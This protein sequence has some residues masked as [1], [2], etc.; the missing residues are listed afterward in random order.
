MPMASLPW[1]GSRPSTK[2]L[3]RKAPALGGSV[4]LNGSDEL[5]GGA[6]SGAEPRVAYLYVENSTGPYGLVRGLIRH[7]SRA[8]SIDQVHV[9]LAYCIELLGTECVEIVARN[10]FG[11]Y[12]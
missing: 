6:E 5:T 3:G 8:K 4:C 2:A 11:K 1:G 12:P 9:A 10:A 7:P